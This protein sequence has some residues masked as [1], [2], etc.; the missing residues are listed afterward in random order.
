MIMPGPGWYWIG[1]EEKQQVLEVMETGHLSRYGDLNDPNFKQKVFTFEREFAQFCG[2]AHCQATSSGTSALMISMRVLGVEPGDEVI[3][4]CY[5]FVASYGAAI[6]LGAVP[7]LAEIDGSLC[8]DP[9]DIEH[10]ITPR[11]KAIMPIHML[12]NPCD[13]EAVLAVARRHN[14]VVIEDGCQACGASYKG[15]RVG[16]F[17]RMAGFS[18]NMFKT[19]T[20]GDGGM[21]V[22]DDPE[23]YEKAFGMQDQ[24]YKPGSGAP[25]VDPPSILGLNF[26]V[27]ELTG[28]VA[29]AQL[30]KLDRITST[31]RRK[32]ALLKET[33]GEIPGARYR[34]LS[35]AEGECGTLL[36]IIF[37]DAERATR[38][39][40]QLGTDTLDHSGWHVYANMDHVNRHLKAIGQP[41]GKGA[42]PRSDD[43]LRRT[44]NLSVGVVDA[45]LGSAYGIHINSTEEEI[46]Q[47]G[48]RVRRTCAEV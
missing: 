11:T 9:A 31:L 14:L 21:L 13:I 6:F 25:R 43:I 23:C 33:I 12:G 17:G 1:E 2:V 46:V 39:A 30:R 8:I 32:K 35:D 3:I 20:T 24:G 36:A 28:A 38:V 45:G 48:Q 37:D 5:G 18:L 44:I 15:K 47:V 27:N 26:R 19:I 40:Q 22:T 4:P 42:Y 34:R 16:S 7:V 10:R 29:L 41:H